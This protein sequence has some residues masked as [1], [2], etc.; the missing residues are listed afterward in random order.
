M[1]SENHRLT[2]VVASFTHM[3]FFT[4]VHLK[5]ATYEELLNYKSRVL[6]NGGIQI[7]QLYS[8]QTEIPLKWV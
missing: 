8:S 7:Q 4:R 5:T 6:K 3:I 2:T 1:L